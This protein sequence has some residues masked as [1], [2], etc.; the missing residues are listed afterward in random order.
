M[1]AI[2]FII[3]LDITIISRLERQ[4]KHLHKNGLIFPKAIY[5]SKMRVLI[6][7]DKDSVMCEPALATCL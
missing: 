5:Q 3:E 2:H 6:E 1:A 4:R 7:S